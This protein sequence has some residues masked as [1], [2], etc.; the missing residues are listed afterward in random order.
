MSI[1]DLVA[2]GF[3]IRRGHE[4]DTISGRREAVEAFTDREWRFFSLGLSE[5]HEYPP[6][7]PPPSLPPVITEFLCAPFFSIIISYAAEDD[8][9]LQTALCE[10]LSP[11]NEL[12]ER[13]LDLPIPSGVI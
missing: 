8:A 3:T 10:V 1:D 2:R 5:C 9:E 13:K 11:D 7:P 12:V 4:L 6:P